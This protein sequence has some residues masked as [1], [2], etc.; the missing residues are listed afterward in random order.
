MHQLEMQAQEDPFLM[1][2]LE[3]YENNG[4]EQQGNLNSL[5]SNL[6]TRVR[7]KKVRRII[8]RQV[9]PIAAS[10]LIALTAGLIFF[11]P[12]KPIHEPEKAVT[13]NILTK[14]TP[15]KA[16]EPKPQLADVV[17]ETPATTNRIKAAKKVTSRTPSSYPDNTLIAMTDAKPAV[18]K[19]D[20][21]IVTINT[22][23]GLAITEVSAQKEIESIKDSI[24]PTLR[25]SAPVIAKLDNQTESRQPQPLNGWKSYREYIKQKAVMPDGET[26][27][28]KLAFVVYANGNIDDF[29][30]IRGQS[31]AMNQKA[32][33]II[34]NGPEWRGDADDKPKQ[35]RLKI[36]FHKAVI[37][38]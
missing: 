34:K 17:K 38:D 15:Q 22:Q 26:G 9:L 12:D 13:I 28:I 19:T 29:K 16:E 36:K 33:E 31:E 37:S 10:L 5:K 1:E 2:A 27:K 6:T 23:H 11:S 25:T 32:I 30:I 4:K 20:T 3:G 7:E 8:F 21:N 14:P 24:K 18:S 35:V